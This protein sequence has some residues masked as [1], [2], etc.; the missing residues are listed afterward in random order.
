MIFSEG[1]T[2]YYRGMG[3]RINWKLL[4]ILLLAVILR[5]WRLDEI[6]G[7]MWGDVI[8]GY[9]FTQ[10]V[11]S[12]DFYWKYEFGG[13]GPLLSY[14]I[15]DLSVIRGLDFMTMKLTTVSIGLL[16]VVAIY[17]LGKLYFNEEVGLWAA[18]FTAISKWNLIFSRL[19]KPHILVVLSAA[20]AF[21]ALLKYLKTFK[22]RYL[23]AGAV[24]T[25]LGMYTQAAF[26]G[27]PL[28]VVC[29]YLVSGNWR[30]KRF[31]KRGLLL[32]VLIV[33]ASIPFFTEIVSDYEYYLGKTAF[34]GE[35]MV[36]D[37][38][39]LMF[40]KNA[41]GNLG[42]NLMMFH[43]RGAR[44]FRDNPSGWP[45]LDVISGLFMIL[46]VLA[47]VK[48]KKS[49]RR[50]IAF[51]IPFFA[52]QIPSLLDTKNLLSAPNA[53]R[54]IGIFP[55]VAVLA[56][57][58]LFVCG[59]FFKK[60][61]FGNIIM[62][63]ILLLMAMLNW[64]QVFNKYARGLPNYNSPFGKIIAGEIDRLP[65]KM[66]VGM[67]GCCWG[68]WG[69]PEPNGVVFVLKDRRPIIMLKNGKEL[70]DALM[71]D[72]SGDGLYAIVSPAEEIL[73]QIGE[74][75]AKDKLIEHRDKYNQLVFYSYSD[76]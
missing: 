57:S 43:V 15:A 74:C 63:L 65:G 41:I 67:V 14:L 7:E 24:I 73:D 19:G 40:V 17:L 45:Q 27:V 18:G 32:G 38:G 52:I 2:R 36:M 3:R 1:H 12:G 9:K 37:G 68:D 26:W 61:K 46:G 42:R 34:F 20:L 56:G 6:P 33:L 48:T 35:K 21:V 76:F 49:F 22:L 11:M 5:L 64:D 13:D 28:A 60:Y 53:G 10:R 30:V 31:W 69:Q 58:G 54:T 50:Q 70:C 55:W 16:S 62:G 44:T 59:K 25:G 66:K 51:W 47:L 23:L 75:I 71:M 4:L 8:E 29:V 72:K 39:R